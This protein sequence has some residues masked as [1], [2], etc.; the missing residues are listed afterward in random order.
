MVGAGRDTDNLPLPGVTVVISGT[1]NGTITNEEGKFKIALPTPNEILVF[2]YIGFLTEE[3]ATS[4]QNQLKVILDED[5]KDIDELVV[6]GYGT[7]KKSDLTGAVSVVEMEDL[8]KTKDISVMKSLQ[9]KTSGIYISTPSGKPGAGSSVKIRGVGSINM[10]A[11]PLYL[12]N[13]NEV[14]SSDINNI[15]PSNI[16]SISILKD[17]SATA[18]YG[19]RGANGVIIIETI[20]GD[21][22]AKKPTVTLDYY[23]GLSK[24]D[25]MYKPLDRDGYRDYMKIVY[26]NYASDK[27]AS[28]TWDS[29]YARDNYYYNYYTDSARA[30]NNNLETNTNQLD[31]LFQTAKVTNLNVNV[32]GGSEKSNYSIG[33]SYS[34]EEGTIIN[35]GY[36]RANFFMNNDIDLIDWLKVGQSITMVNSTSDEL[37]DWYHNG[38][39]LKAGI[40]ASPFMSIYDENAEIGNWGCLVDTLTGGNIVTNAYAE[41]NTYK[42]KNENNNFYGNLYVQMEPIKN[43]QYKI[44]ANYNYGTFE[45]N[46]YKEAYTLGN[47]KQRDHRIDER[48]YYRNIS[49]LYWQLGQLL[50]YNNSSGGLNY[51]IMAGWERNYRYSDNL[52]LRGEGFVSP[53]LT[54]F[55]NAVSSSSISGESRNERKMESYLG[56]IMLDFRNRY[57][58]TA[59]LRAD[60]SSNIAPIKTKDWLPEHYGLFPSFSIGWKLNEDIGVLRDLSFVNLAKLRLGWGVTGNQDITPYQYYNY[61]DAAQYFRYSLGSSQT[62]VLGLG[63]YSTQSNPLIQWEEAR[64]TNA[65]A[66]IN[67]FDNRLQIIAEYDYKNQEKMLVRQPISR[68]MGKAQG[69]KGWYAYPWVN[70]GKVTN[71]GFEFSAVWKQILG[72]IDY[73]IGGNMTTIKNQVV[74]MGAGVG[75]IFVQ[76]EGMN[77]SVTTAGHQIGS[78]Y[79]YVFEGIFQNQEEIDNHA[80]QYNKTS[81]GDMKFKDLNFDG[82]VD[83]NDQTVIG[84]PIP[85]L[86]YGFHGNINYGIF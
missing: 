81:P 40:Q 62:Y 3:V 82:V 32:S 45:S 44:T 55:P 1:M 69:E 38:G 10:N 78:Y 25:G 72:R 24:M 46:M 54:T 57:F 85:T 53:E 60:G 59:S 30:S 6:I 34:N 29:Y 75:D 84:K 49:E 47:I 42:R 28:G 4:G 64:M 2:S 68:S 15:S 70:L 58:L 18:I 5:I 21:R 7:Q 20:K 11:E 8:K 37:R 50:T 63:T 61:M 83:A 16:A 17:A 76:Q 23:I 77:V 79:G 48:D 71:S 19:A 73:S 51:S 12:L 35:T 66:D 31:L 80:F 41:H 13:G 27:I 26:D 36:R 86:I 39:L 74:D 67:L 56:R 9:G 14:K 52:Y 43:L 65:G 22:K 33:G